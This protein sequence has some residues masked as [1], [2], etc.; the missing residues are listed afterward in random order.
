MGGCKKLRSVLKQWQTR[1]SEMR[2][3]DKG[4]YENTL[5]GVDLLICS[6]D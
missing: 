3:G 5:R 4:V 2:G 6:D 1:V